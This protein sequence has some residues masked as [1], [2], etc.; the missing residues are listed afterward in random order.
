MGNDRHI[1]GIGH[2]N[3]LLDKTVFVGTLGAFNGKIDT[4]G[5]CGLPL[6]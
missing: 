1:K 3:G 2:A 4:I 5:K 6:L